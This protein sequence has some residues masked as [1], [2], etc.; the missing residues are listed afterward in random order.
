MNEKE[1]VQFIR[2]AELWGYMTFLKLLNLVLPTIK[3][4]QVF[5]RKIAEGFT[6]FI[7]RRIADFEV[8]GFEIERVD[9]WMAFSDEEYLALAEMN[10]LVE[11]E[12]EPV[13]HISR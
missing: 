6:N 13:R 2:T 8:E 12:S 3:Q 11:I 10:N 1:Q 4:H 9:T 5:Y 7:V